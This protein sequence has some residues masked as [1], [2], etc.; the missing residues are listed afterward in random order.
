MAAELSLEALREEID[1]IDEV[2]VRLLDRRA[3]CAYA[4]GRIKKEQGATIYEPAREA[5]VMAHIKEV[6]TMLGGPLD[7]GAIVRLYERIMDEA[8]RIQRIEAKL[9]PEPPP[10]PDDLI[11]RE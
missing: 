6:N 2:I 8:R 4:I 9:E 1:K 5:A 7:E 10:A 11:E 3:R